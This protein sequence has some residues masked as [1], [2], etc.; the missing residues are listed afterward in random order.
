[1][2]AETEITIFAFNFVYLIM[3]TI[4]IVPFDLFTYL[5][6]MTS[7]SFF[8]IILSAMKGD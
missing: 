2:T 1:M 7:A 6:F 3:S 5:I 8:G 4:G